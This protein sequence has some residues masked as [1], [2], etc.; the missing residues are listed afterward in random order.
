MGSQIAQTL[1]KAACF[2][3]CIERDPQYSAAWKALGKALTELGDHIASL[4]AYTQGIAAAEAK[5]ALETGW[6][7]GLAAGRSAAEVFG[8]PPVVRG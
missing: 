5:L 1:T 3:A 8:L 2:Q 6:T 7:T 4:A